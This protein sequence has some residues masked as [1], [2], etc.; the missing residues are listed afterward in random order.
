M[1][2]LD[3]KLA[4][5][6]GSPVFAQLGERKLRELSPYTDDV[7]VPAG[8]TLME[9]G[10]RAHELAVLVE[11]SASVILHGKPVKEVGPGDVIGE[12]AL[13]DHGLRTATVVTTSEAKLI[14]ING[15]HFAALLERFPEIAEDLRALARA[16]SEEDAAATTD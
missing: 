10:S 5:L 3:P 15:A 11:G 13:L 12:M 2:K 16:R 6:A 4:R 7:T 8:T 9:E 1:S 14:V